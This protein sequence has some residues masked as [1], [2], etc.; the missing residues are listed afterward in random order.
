[1]MADRV[2]MWGSSPK[3]LLFLSIQREKIVRK[4][5]QHSFSCELEFLVGERSD[6]AFV[7]LRDPC[8]LC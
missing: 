1:M 3:V 2:E 6:S 7:F 4:L 5:R 8:A